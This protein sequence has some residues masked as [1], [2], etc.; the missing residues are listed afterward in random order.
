MPLMHLEM[1]LKRP[2]GARFKMFLIGGVFQA[3]LGVFHERHK[4]FFRVRDDARTRSPLPSVSML[5]IFVRPTNWKENMTS[6]NASKQIIKESRRANLHIGIES[7]DRVVQ[8]PSIRKGRINGFASRKR[9]F[10]DLNID[11]D[12][13]RPLLLG[14]CS[15]KVHIGRMKIDNTDLPLIDVPN[16]APQSLQIFLKRLDPDKTIF[17][18]HLNPASIFQ[19]HKNRKLSHEF[20]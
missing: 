8:K 10:H 13:G 6:S 5:R 4:V 7:Q 3:P 12:I 11:F 17:P 14:K 2:L 1:T 20:F 15:G 16:K 19:G 18:G 9:S